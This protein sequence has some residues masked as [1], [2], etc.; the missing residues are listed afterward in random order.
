MKTKTV[1]M[2]DEVVVWID[3][4]Y[5]RG[6]LNAVRLIENGLKSGLSYPVVL[7]IVRNSIKE[8]K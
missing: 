1:S 5:K 2:E 6:Y 3:E 7:G 8:V 4:S